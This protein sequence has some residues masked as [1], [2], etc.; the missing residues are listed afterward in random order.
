MIWRISRRRRLS[1]TIFMYSQ[2]VNKERNRHS[3]SCDFCSGPPSA[4]IPVGGGLFICPQ[5]SRIK[6]LLGQSSNVIY[7]CPLIIRD[8]LG[9]GTNSVRI[10]LEICS[11]S[12]FTSSSLPLLYAHKS[13]YFRHLNI[14]LHL[15]SFYKTSTLPLL[16]LYFTSTDH[17]QH[18]KEV[19]PNSIK[20]CNYSQLG[21]ITFPAWERNIPSLGINAEHR[22]GE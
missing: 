9:Y 20:E 4:V 13:L 11:K 21:N 1:I 14:A 3:P 2:N 18:R 16:I 19:A 12:Q 10:N 5:K 6:R 22:D 15:F 17:L 8:L 7:C